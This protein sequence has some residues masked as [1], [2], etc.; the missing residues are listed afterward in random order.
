[1][2]IPETIHRDHLDAILLAP[3]GDGVVRFKATMP[4]HTTEGRMLA[5]LYADLI[6]RGT[7]SK[8]RKQF[9]DAVDALGARLDI[10][11]DRVGITVSGSA[12]VET[13]PKFLALVR[14]MLEAPAFDPKELKQVHRQYLQYL[15][16][17][18]DNARGRAYITF[19]Q[20]L[21]P[22]NHPYCKPKTAARRA[23]LRMVT[24]K[25]Y[26]DFH[27]ALFTTGMSVSI[28]GD[29][30]S[31]KHMIDLFLSL[32]AES[33]P[34][35]QAR[36]APSVAT[37]TPATIYQSV[38]SKSNIELYIGNALPLTFSDPT[39]LPFQFGLNVLGKW[40]GFS[41][42]LMSTVREK[43]G[44]TYMTYAR[45]EGVTKTE[46]GVW[47]V[48][49]FFTPRDLDKGLASTRREIALIA[50]KGVTEKEMTRFKELL[51]NQFILA[52]ESDAAALG[53][54]H[55]ALAS[56]ITPD[57]VAA[58]YQAMQRLTKKTVDAA[59]RTHLT[60]DHL[61]ISGAGPITSKR[62]V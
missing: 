45:T 60:P 4:V 24:R 15:E 51:Q 44:L 43:E 61:V 53:M 28:C 41:G 22:K 47:Y 10:T 58:Q 3:Q 54:Y 9:A 17:E 16:D 19:T 56:G 40:G 14:E 35:A 49:T 38:P 20:T 7:K 11:S 31:Q 52:H 25:T 23:H 34:R 50:T 37:H 59:L 6:L 18:E 27:T 5:P 8:T 2:R 46:E 62:M 30:K 29:A 26:F 21:F 13:F 1:M 57:E 39:F 36:A 55:D 33:A 48:A 42:R 12:L 32:G